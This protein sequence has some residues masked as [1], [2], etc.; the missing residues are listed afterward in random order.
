MGLADI[1]ISDISARFSS[2]S[3][4]RTFIPASIATA[5]YSFAF[6]GVIRDSSWLGLSFEEKIIV[7]IIVSL[8]INGI[9]LNLCDTYIYQLYE[10]ILWP[11]FLKRF[12]YK[13]QIKKFIKFD[14]E[15]KK[16]YKQI[17][18][19]EENIKKLNSSE[20]E[21]AEEELWRLSDKLSQ[22]SAELRKFPY[23]PDYWY[24]F[25]WDEIPKKDSYRF[26]EYLKQN[27]GIN[28]LRTAKIDKTNSAVSIISKNN[29]LSLRLNDEKTKAMLTV[30]D[31]N[32]DEFIVKTEDGKLNIY[33]NS[34]SKRFPENPTELGNVIAEYELYSEKQYGM[35]MM[36]FWQHLWLILPK[37]LRDDLDLRSAKADFNVHVSFVLLTFAFI[38]TTMFAFDSWYKIFSWSFPLKAVAS[39]LISLLGLF[40]FY[41]LS[42]SEHKAYGRYIK[43]AFDLYRFDLAKKFNIKISEF[44]E[45]EKKSWEIRRRFFL[46]YRQPEK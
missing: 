32:A 44:P 19:L 27:F 36:V 30:D 16:T 37:E 8:L 40:V 41:K 42:I 21:N 33:Y 43:A 38:G 29:S 31:V 34:Y 35:H 28:W 11:T 3:Y 13:R 12:F 25:S 22:L 1:P 4:I 26:I 5:L 15:L 6:Y 45:I 9:L 20:R 23:N 10:G 14:N 18:I 46:D 7:F 39:A 17:T 24:L 2:S